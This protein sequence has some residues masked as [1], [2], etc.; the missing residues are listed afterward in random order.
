MLQVNIITLFPDFFDS[1]LKVGILG[2]V[3]YSGFLKI[4]FVNPRDFTED[5]HQSVDDNPFGGRDG[6]VMKYE[7]LRKAIEF[8]SETRLG[9]VN[10]SGSLSKFGDKLVKKKSKSL[11]KPE[12]ALKNSPVKLKQKI[13]YLSPQGKKWD[14]VKARALA[15]QSD[16]EWTFICGRYAGVDQRFISE[17]VEEEISVGDYVLTGGEPAMVVILDSLSRF[18]KRALGN[19]S[20]SIDESFEHQSLL[21]APQWTRPQKISGYKIP[22]VVLSG[23]HKNIEK[24]H[25]LM[26]VLITAIKRPE[27][28]AF[29]QTKKDLPEAVKMVQSFSKEEL[30]ACGLSLECLRALKNRKLF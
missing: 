6:M 7:P 10:N 19:G 28:L 11:N 15:E 23:H 29:C 30:R 26:S 5:V 18:I 24:F 3:I 14:Y 21:E 9:Y 17:Y 13:I 25:Y 22:E 1:P 2:R 27:L 20:S 16:R 12:I 8:L 4:R